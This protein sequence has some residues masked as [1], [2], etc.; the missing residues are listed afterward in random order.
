MNPLHERKSSVD[1]CQLVTGSWKQAS[2]AELRRVECLSKQYAKVVT[3]GALDSPLGVGWHPGRG[4]HVTNERSI[5]PT[6][7]SQQREP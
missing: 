7:S 3:D 1:A 6:A 4:V 5:F 2:G